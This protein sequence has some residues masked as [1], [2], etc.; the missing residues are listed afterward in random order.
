MPDSDKRRSKLLQSMLDTDWIE[1]SGPSIKF[2]IER[3]IMAHKVEILRAW[4]DLETFKRW[5]VP[6]GQKLNYCVFEATGTLNW[7]LQTTN[8]VS[9]VVEHTLECEEDHF[10]TRLQFVYYN[11]DLPRKPLED[12]VM[13]SFDLDERQPIASLPCTFCALELYCDTSSLWKQANK[14]DMHTFWIDAVERLA[15]LVE[16]ESFLRASKIL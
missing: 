8:D 2:T 4:C 10:D 13:L 5:I 15:K 6:T 16:Q 9:R 1:S 14:R 12:A 3:F 7:T 11:S